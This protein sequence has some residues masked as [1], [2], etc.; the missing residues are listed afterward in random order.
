MPCVLELDLIAIT[1]CAVSTVYNVT[2]VIKDNI[3]NI[4]FSV[5]V[6]FVTVLSY[7]GYL[8]TVTMY[9]ATC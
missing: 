2:D 7:P 4:C 5:M 6:H 1:Q 3:I 8:E 9:T